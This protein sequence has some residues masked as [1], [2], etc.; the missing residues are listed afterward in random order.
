M[1]KYQ[2]AVHSS[3]NKAALI[4]ERVRFTKN[5]NTAKFDQGL[6][7]DRDLTKE[8]PEYWNNYKEIS[9]YGE[10]VRIFSTTRRTSRFKGRCALSG[11]G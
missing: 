1:G 10:A 5:M 7:D 11:C 9:A 2:F 4:P 6:K 3:R 8:D